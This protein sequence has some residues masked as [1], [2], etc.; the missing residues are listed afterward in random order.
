MMGREKSPVKWSERII[1]LDIIL[2][3]IRWDHKSEQNSGKKI[4]QNNV[5]GAIIF[6]YLLSF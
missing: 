3:I 1:D 2:N 4:R 5:F 6:L